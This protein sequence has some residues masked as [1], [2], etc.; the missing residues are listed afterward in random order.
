MKAMLEQ[1]HLTMP[2]FPRVFI[3]H[4]DSL[5]H[6]VTTKRPVSAHPEAGHEPSLCSLVLCLSSAGH[7]KNSGEWCMG[8]EAGIR[9]CNLPSE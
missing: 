2:I 5:G 1:L 4:L 9:S 6:T 3:L 8:E 7:C